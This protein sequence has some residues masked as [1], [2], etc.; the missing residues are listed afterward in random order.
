MD[1]M[2]AV[3]GITDAHHSAGVA[4]VTGAARGIG[5]AV[6]LRLARDGYDV[7]LLDTIPEAEAV[8]EDIRRLGRGALFVGADVSDPDQV[9]A[10][11]RRVAADLGTVRVLVNDA[12][13]YPRSA[14]LELDW[15]T[16]QR[17]LDV[18]LGGTFLC[19]RMFA[20]R[21]V[22]GD[23]GAIVNIASSKAVTG[24]AEGAHYAASKGGIVALTKSLAMEWAPTVRVNA[25]LPGLTMTDLARGSGASDDDIRARA[26]AKV[27][28]GRVGEPDDVAGVVAFLAGPDAAYMTGASLHVNGGSLMV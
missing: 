7:A 6:A 24:A 12:G 18:N 17:V 4:V 28:L 16:W 2:G 14:A 10:A 13:V 20:A 9:A 23:G 8:A 11:E 3:D 15:S 22:G 27:P 19:S 5:R 25:V 21:M 26:R 1:G